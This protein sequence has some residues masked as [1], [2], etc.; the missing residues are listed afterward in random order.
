MD[1]FKNYFYAIA[2]LILTGF[3]I[4]ISQTIF[5]PLL[6]GFILA[7]ALKPLAA[8]LEYIK[9]PRL[10][11]TILAMLFLL[12]IVFGLVFVFSIQVSNINF[13]AASIQENLDG[14][15]KIRDKVGEL[16]GLTPKEQASLLAKA[17]SN[18]IETGAS[19]FQNTVSFTTD[20][21]TSIVLFMIG[22]FF[23]L[24]Y[25]RLFVL[26]L[27]RAVSP[28]H[29]EALS[30]ILI[31][32]QSV[33]Y[34]Y[35]VGLSLVILVVAILNSIGLLILGVDNALFFG[36]LAAVLTLIPYI[37]ITIGSILPMVF[38]LLTTGS[39]WYCLGVLAVFL[40]VQGIEGNFLTPNIVG[41]QVRINPFA[42][43]LGLVV[44]GMFLGLIGVIF[45][46]PVLAMLKVVFD[47]IPLF[48][49]IGYL[50]EIP[51]KAVTKAK[52]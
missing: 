25:R 36:M 31:K 10:L 39:L 2:S 30:H 27:H 14:L 22:L 8:D 23:F 48:Q 24:Y 6:A 13:E 29:H 11:S 35:I 51:D 47:E 38:V 16:I 20:F 52:R 18:F 45:A 34:H 3:L 5:N 50:I 4:Y 15:Y 41:R 1:V 44:G 19:I 26:F 32:I 49:P 40:V 9:V 33:V 43:I 28:A 12:F 46:L 42:A 37:G 17:Y 21:M 7:L